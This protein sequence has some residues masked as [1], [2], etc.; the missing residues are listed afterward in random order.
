MASL[1]D[2]TCLDKIQQGIWSATLPLEIRL[3]PSES[4]IYDKADPYLVSQR[5]TL[6]LDFTS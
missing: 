2:P 4:R 6:Y 1:K 5:Y 3:S